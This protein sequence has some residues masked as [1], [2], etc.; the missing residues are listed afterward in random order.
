MSDSKD[1]NT[2]NRFKNKMLKIVDNAANREQPQSV[3]TERRNK[4]AG[5]QLRHLTGESSLFAVMGGGGG[6]G[7]GA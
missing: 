2:I 5:H 1:T 4:N 6:T 7:V 3:L